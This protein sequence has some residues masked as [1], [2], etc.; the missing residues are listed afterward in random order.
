MAASNFKSDYGLLVSGDSTLLGNVV[1]QNT[2]VVVANSIIPASNV[3]LLGNT[4]ARWVVSGVRGDFSSTLS[5][6]G[7]VAINT[8]AFTVS[9]NTTAV[10][11]GV[12]T[13]A[14]DSTL[15]V[16]GTANVSGAAWFG[17]TVTAV[18]N[19]AVGTNA[20]V[21]DATNKLVRVGTSDVSNGCVVGKIQYTLLM[22]QAE[23]LKAI[24]EFLA[25]HDMAPTTF[26]RLSCG[27]GAA[28]G[29]LRK[30]LGITLRRAEQMRQF[31]SEYDRSSGKPRPKR[32]RSEPFMA[33]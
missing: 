28:L 1:V 6:A 3:S 5:A 22:T 12:N 32:S 25:R 18:G 9:S 30:G 8:S 27:D 16:V 13:A 26:G 31:M 21:V 23:L 2:S 17:Q 14:P 24:D 4:T 19:V 10:R 11:V 33:A 15:S 7:N 29:R 20:L